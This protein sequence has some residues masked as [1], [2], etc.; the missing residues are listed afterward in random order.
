MPNRNRERARPTRPDASLKLP[1]LLNDARGRIEEIEREL[2]AQVE[3]TVLIQEQLDELR[4][5]LQ[6]FAR[7]ASSASQ[8]QPVTGARVVPRQ[9]PL[10]LVKRKAKTGGRGL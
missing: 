4:L 9:Y 10:G 3:G 5:T 1:A 6:S 2:A 8:P 7:M